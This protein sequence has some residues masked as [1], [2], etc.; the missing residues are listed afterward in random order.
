MMAAE[1]PLIAAIIARLGDPAINL[2]AYGVAYA[3]A[4]VTEAPIIMLMSAATAL[5]REQH[6]YR[7]LKY[8]SLVLCFGV[9]ATLAILC[10]PPLFAYI[11]ITG[12]GL[13]PVV[14]W[15]AHGALLCL[16]PWPA[17]I[18]M[19]RFYQG[20]LIRHGQTQRIAIGTAVRL[21]GMS[22]CA[23]L[24]AAY[25]P[26]DGT[27]IGG[28]ALSCGVV[29]EA[30]IIRFLATGVVRQ[31]KACTTPHPE[32]A[33]TLRRLCAASAPSTSPLP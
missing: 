29:A 9:T 12:V 26:L 18:G 11:A 16:L 21:V 30:L 32:G 27:R 25:S 28:A 24:L 13:Q 5:V 23:L 3:F 2:A 6:S 31:I 7:Q 15:H 4:L 10:I 33:L 17:A 8:F 22:S 20:L 14:A 19:R 1:G